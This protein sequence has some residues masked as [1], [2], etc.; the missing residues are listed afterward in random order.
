MTLIQ[1]RLK[2]SGSHVWLPG[3]SIVFV[4]VLIFESLI[5]VMSF[6][7]F[8][9]IYPSHLLVEIIEVL[10]GWN[11]HSFQFSNGAI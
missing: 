1:I 8:Q 4:F 3:N 7:T 6:S 9:N 5:F 10:G 2:G 11:R